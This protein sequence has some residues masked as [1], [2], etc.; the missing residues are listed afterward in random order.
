MFQTNKNSFGL[1]PA[2]Q[3]VS[4]PSLAPGASGHTIV[5]LVA[6]PNKVVPGELSPTLQVRCKASTHLVHHRVYTFGDL[7]HHRVKEGGCHC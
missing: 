6:D 7:A 1:S 5:P 3:V 4:I 2:D